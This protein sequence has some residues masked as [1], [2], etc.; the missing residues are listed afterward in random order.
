MG[1]M[2]SGKHALMTVLARAIARSDLFSP[3]D[4]HVCCSG[5][6]GQLG[7]VSSLL[8]RGVR[9][10][11]DASSLTAKVPFPYPYT[12]WPQLGACESRKQRCSICGRSQGATQQIAS[13]TVA[14]GA[15]VTRVLQLNRELGEGGQRVAAPMSATRSPPR[16]GE[17]S[18]I[19]G[20]MLPRACMHATPLMRCL[21]RSTPRPRKRCRH[22]SGTRAACV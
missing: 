21:Q 8:F 19:A 9:G 20:T 22:A 12:C 16:T 18:M 5:R 2:L 4:A 14:N 17:A 11:R 1:A 15:T 7:C 3:A 13:A 6:W 10:S